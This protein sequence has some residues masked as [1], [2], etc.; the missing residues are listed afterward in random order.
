MYLFNLSNEVLYYVLIGVGAILGFL[1]AFFL[2]KNK[3]LF[4]SIFMSI[5]GGAFGYLIGTFLYEIIFLHI[6]TG[7]QKIMNIIILACCMI[8]GIV[9]GIFA[10]RKICI[11][12]TSTIGGY[13]F[14]RGIALFLDG[15]DIKYIDESKVFDY[16]RTENYEQI[17]DMISSYFFLFPAIFVL[18]TVIYIAIQHKINPKDPEED[19]YK[20]LERKF[21]KQAK[22]LRIETSSSSFSDEGKLMEDE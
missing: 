18:F 3:K 14:M 15:T 13:C 8:L 10:P 21:N 22:D 20:E 12:S 11:I 16:A 9:L 5:L 7:S 19:E 2:T 17:K 1:V 4:L 6:E